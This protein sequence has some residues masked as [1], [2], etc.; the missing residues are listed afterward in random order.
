MDNVTKVKILKI[1]VLM[2]KTR[3]TKLSRPSHKFDCTQTETKLTTKNRTEYNLIQIRSFSKIFLNLW[4]ET[5]FCYEWNSL[6]RY[7]EGYSFYVEDG[8]NRKTLSCHQRSL[9]LGPPLTY[10][11]LRCQGKG[12]PYYL[13]LPF[14][15]P[16][17][18]L[19]IKDWTNTCN[20]VNKKCCSVNL[21]M[22]FSVPPSLFNSLNWVRCFTV[23]TFKWD[24][25]VRDVKSET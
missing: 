2:S 3:P 12:P 25:I 20:R 15:T 10:L 4:R 1:R 7:E 13:F 11:C 14:D 8:S 22:F 5:L 21:W 23:L 19:V 24:S 6:N 18:S 16:C 9:V 17:L